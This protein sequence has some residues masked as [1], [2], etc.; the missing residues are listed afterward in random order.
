MSVAE[1]A[2]YLGLRFGANGALSAVKEDLDSMLKRVT[3]APLKPAQRL[4]ILRHKL[5]R[6]GAGG[7][8]PARL[9]REIGPEGPNFA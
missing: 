5:L 2:K 3:A 1:T 4:W 9:I 8:E 6:G 7:A